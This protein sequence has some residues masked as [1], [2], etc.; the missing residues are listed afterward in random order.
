MNQLHKR[1]NRAYVRTMNKRLN[2]AYIRT[3]N[4]KTKVDT[5]SALNDSGQCQHLEETDKKVVEAE[6]LMLLNK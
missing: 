6:S 1:L 2:R 4:I 5:N 3:M